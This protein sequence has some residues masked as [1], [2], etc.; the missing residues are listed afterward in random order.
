M[1][2]GT[3]KSLLS[4]ILAF[5]VSDQKC[6]FPSAVILLYTVFW[7]FY[8]PCWLL[9][10]VLGFFW[11]GVVCLFL[12]CLVG[13]FFPFLAARW[14]MEF[15]SQGFRSELQLWPM[16]QLQQHRILNPLCRARDRARDRT[17]HPALPR[18][19]WSHWT[20]AG[21]LMFLLRCKIYA[22][23]C[24]KFYIYSSVPFWI[25]YICVTMTI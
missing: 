23:K 6:A 18:C 19:C 1:F 21:T 20:M 11:M 10:K 12:V 14:Y 3:L 2:P 16:L 15:P 4:Y 17:F 13:W 8:F 25:L 24:T 9:F 22:I 5:F 7:F